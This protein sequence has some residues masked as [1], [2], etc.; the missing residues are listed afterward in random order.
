MLKST[1]PASAS[2]ASRIAPAD[3][4]RGESATAARMGATMP[5]WMR[6]PLLHF[7][8]LGA[9]LFGADHVLFARAGDPRVIV[10]GEDVTREARDLFK[11]SSG[12]EPTPEELTALR[13]R[14]LDNEVLYREG[15]AM[16]VDKGDIA[17]RERV[18][19]KALSV[20]DANVEMPP[21]DDVVVSKWFEAH[22]SRYDQPARFDFQEAVLAG[23]PSESVVR[24]FAAK[25]NAG[26]PGDADAGLR[27]FKDRPLGN[28][29]QS[30]GADFATALQVAQPGLWQ[31]VRSKDGWRAVRLDARMAPKPSSYAA[32]R[33]D[34]LQDWKDATLAEQ[35]SA[36]VRALTK[37]YTVR[38]ERAAS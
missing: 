13:N 16:Q 37:K 6:E 20:I 11:A 9:V 24:A 19:F 5:R 7:V 29:T 35:R 8:V 32:L 1:I 38:D 22:R 34:V 18:I 14:W 27:V 30:Y 21:V 4:L 2:R 36:A 17:L 28:V 12:R 33:N 25:L 15:L 26:A 10:V 23:D 31:A 3:R